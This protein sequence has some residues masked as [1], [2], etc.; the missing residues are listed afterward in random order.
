ML[1]KAQVR[2]TQLYW[3]FGAADS[4]DTFGQILKDMTAEDIEELGGRYATYV[5]VDDVIEDKR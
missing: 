4:A 5:D 1:Y 3:V 2:V